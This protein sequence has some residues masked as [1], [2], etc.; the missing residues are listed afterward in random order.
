MKK[1]FALV[2]AVAMMLSMVS[3]ATAEGG[4]VTTSTSSPKPMKPGRLWL[5]PTPT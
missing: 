1:L 5:R 3:F 2:L 4:K